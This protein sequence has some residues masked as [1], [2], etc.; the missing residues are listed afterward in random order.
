MSE[1]TDIAGLRIITYFEDEV[2]KIAELISKEFEIDKKNSIDKRSVIE[3]NEFG[4]MS[5]H[6]VVELNNSRKELTEYRR[7]KSMKAEIQIR[8]ILQHA[9]AEIEHDLGYKSSIEVPRDIRRTF[10]RIAGILETAD[11][12]FVTVKDELIKYENEIDTKIKTESE[13]VYLDKL[14]LTSYI[15]SSKIVNEIDNEIKEYCI[16]I[17][18]EQEYYYEG[19]LKYLQYCNITTIDMLDEM[20]IKNKKLIIYL[21]TQILSQEET[22]LCIGIIIFYFVYSYILENKEQGYF[23]KFF[24]AFNFRHT[25]EDN[26]MDE[27]YDEDINF[28]TRIYSIY[29]NYEIKFK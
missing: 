14:S 10:S 29:N 5:L 19:L 28:I 17:L 23:E 18:E 13:V 4:Y 3:P 20:L 22:N 8:T 26:Y 11:R 16:C 12:E 9:W 25:E 24:N 2:N 1:I 15:R 21:A 7:F 27:E 6:L